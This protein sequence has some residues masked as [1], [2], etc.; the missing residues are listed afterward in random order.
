MLRIRKSKRKFNSKWY[1]LDG[2]YKHFKRDAIRHAES[3]R[4]SGKLA[5]ITENVRP[6]GYS[7]VDKEYYVWV[8][9][10]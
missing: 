1:I 7:Q 6:K 4:N 5:R 10:R 9:K 2:I 8:R 3:A